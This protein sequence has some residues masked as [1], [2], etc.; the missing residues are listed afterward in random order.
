M[1]LY[2]RRVDGLIDAARAADAQLP[3]D[4]TLAAL[5][6][7]GLRE[8]RYG[9]L[10]SYLRNAAVGGDGDRAPKTLTDAYLM[11]MWWQE[12]LRP[13]VAAAAD[14]GG[15]GPQQ[16]VLATVESSEHDD[17]AADNRGARGGKDKKRKK[18]NGKSR[19]DDSSESSRERGGA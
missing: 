3:A 6:V 18:R 19:G 15:A 8:D 10:K 16:L 2:K 5:F 12:Q 14:F 7:E 4:S 11:T 17:G 9:G 1:E 13:R